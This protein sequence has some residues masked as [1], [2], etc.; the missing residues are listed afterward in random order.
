MLNQYKTTENKEEG[1]HEDPKVTL[2]DKERNIKPMEHRGIHQH[3][4]GKDQT[5]GQLQGER[6][7]QTTHE[8][9][10]YSCERCDYITEW[11]QQM[12]RH[13]EA[14][15]ENIKYTC[16]LFFWFFFFFPFLLTLQYGGIQ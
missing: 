9:V 2:S 7:I 6:Q 5:S 12:K 14:V 3:Y 1:Q 11:K 8:R 4:Q 16:E 10:K 13:K 15:H